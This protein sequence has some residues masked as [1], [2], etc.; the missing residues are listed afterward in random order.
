MLVPQSCFSSIDISLADDS[1]K[2]SFLRFTHPIEVK[3]SQDFDAS[4]F[5][6]TRGRKEVFAGRVSTQNFVSGD[7][8]SSTAHDEMPPSQHFSNVGVI[9]TMT[10]RRFSEFKFIVPKPHSP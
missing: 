2:T 4:Q 1:P 6:D 8:A 5:Y 10:I 3:Y 7:P 9:V